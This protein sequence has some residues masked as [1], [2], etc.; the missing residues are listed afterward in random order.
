MLVPHLAR[1]AGDSCD[2]RLGAHE[3]VEDR[4]EDHE[5]QA[6]EVV[7]VDLGEVAQAFIQRIGRERP[8][9]IHHVFENNLQATQ[10]GSI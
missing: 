6:D 8:V 4:E 10:Q 9:R 1:L 3:E 2:V 7:V 5:D